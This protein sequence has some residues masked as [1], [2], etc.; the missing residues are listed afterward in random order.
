MGDKFPLETIRQR[1]VIA[2]NRAQAAIDEMDHII[3]VQGDPM[4]T[5]AEAESVERQAKNA[6]V[7]IRK[8]KG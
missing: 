6:Q 4:E 3:V 7:L 1:F 8:Y 5:L 2:K